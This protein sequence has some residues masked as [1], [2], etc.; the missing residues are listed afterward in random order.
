MTTL[1]EKFGLNKRLI[2]KQVDKNKIAIVKK[3]K[4]RIMQKDAQKI[5]DIADKIKSIDSDKDVSLICTL[6]IC[7]KSVKL[8]NQNNI[9]IIFE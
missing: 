1:S 3:I 9:E 7:S 4:S 6:N 8:L 5:V 2:L